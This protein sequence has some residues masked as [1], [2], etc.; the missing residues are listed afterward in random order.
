MCAHVCVYILSL[1]QKPQIYVVIALTYHYVRFQ[2]LM[3]A[4][5]KTTAFCC[6]VSLKST[7]VSQVRSAPIIKV[8]EVTGLTVTVS[9]IKAKCSY[10]LWMSWV[11]PGGPPETRRL[12]TLNDVPKKHP[13]FPVISHW[14][15]HGNFP[16]GSVSRKH[17]LAEGLEKYIYITL[18]LWLTSEIY[19]P[20]IPS[21]I[22]LRNTVSPQTVLRCAYTRQQGRI[23]GKPARQQPRVPAYKGHWNITRIN[24]KYG[25]EHIYKKHVTLKGHQIISLPGASA[26]LGP[27]LPSKP[28][29]SALRNSHCLDKYIDWVFLLV[30]P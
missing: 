21:G 20:C 13:T 29:E 28:S 15:V 1:L 16:S 10:Q 12:C 4:S 6:V 7:D 11:L 18:L 17:F 26:C 22:V 27:V 23:R 8:M 3:V 25:V 30:V 9:F 24:C 14:E 2:V 5:M 19:R